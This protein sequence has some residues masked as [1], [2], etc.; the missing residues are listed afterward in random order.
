MK[1]IIANNAG[2]CGGV[3]RA[4]RMAEEALET[5]PEVGVLGTLIHNPQ[6]VH[7]L[8]ERGMKDYA[9]SLPK[10]PS[11]VVSKSHGVCKE[12]REELKSLGHTVVETTCPVLTKMY[13]NIEREWKGGATVV[14]VGDPAH[15]EIQA[16]NSHTD[17]E[18]L[19]VPDVEKAKEVKD[20]S[21]LYVISQTTN[22]K[23]LFEEVLAV[24]ESNNADVRGENTICDATRLRQESC[25]A[26]AKEADAMLVIGGRESSN[27]K[28]LGQVA[29][30][31]CENV[32]VIEGKEDLRDEWIDD[33]HTLGVT[34]GA[35]TPDFVIQEVVEE[36]QRIS[37]RKRGK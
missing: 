8:S 28:K 27:T 25:A 5:H 17:Y 34:A 32:Y 22:R 14:I 10:E 11:V 12:T 3:G 1:I 7:K 18:A 2:F 19:V 23:E 35:S 21:N 4:V 29:S 16:L 26:L 31:F 20:L 30:Q 37:E 15:P 36:A 13:G 9:I 6:M 33:V 24:L